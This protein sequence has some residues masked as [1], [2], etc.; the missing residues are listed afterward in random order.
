MTSLHTPLLQNPLSVYIF[1]P[2][3]RIY[4]R[5][6]AQRRWYPL[7]MSLCTALS[8]RYRAPG[9][10]QLTPQPTRLRNP[11]RYYG[12]QDWQEEGETTALCA[13]CD[14]PEGKGRLPICIPPVNFKLCQ[15][16]RFQR[17]PL[18][19]LDGLSRLS[20]SLNPHHSW[21]TD[22][23]IEFV[24]YYISF[25]S[26]VKCKQARL[27][28]SGGAPTPLTLMSSLRFQHSSHYQPRY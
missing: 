17:E 3:S 2:Q 9:I 19:L 10:N 14:F 15:C 4:S 1:W 7:I 6:S 20:P 8:G 28:R 11:W 25:G 16:Q 21:Q 22:R 23:Y 24:H 12:S 18:T 27:P 13:S 26:L 5:R